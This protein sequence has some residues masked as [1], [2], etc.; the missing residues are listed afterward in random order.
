MLSPSSPAATLAI[1]GGVTGGSSEAY[2]TDTIC[3]FLGQG[4]AGRAWR[5][6]VMNR[7]GSSGNPP[8]TAAYGE[9][10]IGP[11]DDVR[12]FMG[13]VHDA[14]PAAVAMV[15]VGYSSGANYLAR[16]LGEDG[17]EVPLDAAFA[18]ANG[19][20]FDRGLDILHAEEPWWE[21]V[22]LVGV[23]AMIERSRALFEVCFTS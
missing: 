1:V 23:K 17:G 11:T 21:N 2:C 5:V 7:R 10:E 20:N 19:W 22:L 9:W 12:H 14:F 16:Y 8:V 18:V 4:E 3:E 13:R 6:A 15:G